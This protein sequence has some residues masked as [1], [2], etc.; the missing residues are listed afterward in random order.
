MNTEF[1]SGNIAAAEAA[2]LARPKVVMAYPITPQTTVIETIAK[3]CAQGKMN[4]KF[5][6]MESEHS[7][8][9]A[10]LASIAGGVRVFT[11][12]SSQGLLYGLEG[13]YWAGGGRFPL[14]MVNVNRAPCSPWALGPSLDDAMAA[15]AS[16]CILMFCE[17]AQE[18][19]DT[20]LCCYRL[21]EELNIPSIINYPGFIVSNAYENVIIPSQEMVDKFLPT[22]VPKFVLDPEIPYSIGNAMNSEDYTKTK[23]FLQKDMIKIPSVAQGI[24]VDFKKMFGRKY[25]MEIEAC[26]IETCETLVITMET[27]ISAVR[28]VTENDP[29]VGFV[30]IKMFNPFPKKALRSVFQTIKK[31][32]GVQNFERI[33]VLDRNLYPGEGGHTWLKV[34]SMLTGDCFFRTILCEPECYKPFIFNYIVGLNGANITSEDIQGIVEDSKKRYGERKDEEIVF[35]GVE[36]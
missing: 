19:L 12:T 1:I 10:A 17:D 6:K 5:K 16:G 23:L 24:S 26:N 20:I 4:A 28:E 15:Q 18:I 35:W 3:F 30:K 31:R 33:I 34:R 36:K 13:V 8:I 22:F 9:Q 32:L 25:E 14:V 21:S 29:K 27:V 2:R 11:A 7:M